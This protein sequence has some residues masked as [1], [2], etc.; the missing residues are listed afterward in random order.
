MQDWQ[1]RVI[2]EKVELNT[3]LVKLQEFLCSV[4]FQILKLL[5]TQYFY[6]SGYSEILDERIARFEA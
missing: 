3:K 1:E 2:N 6:M 5:K 4:Q